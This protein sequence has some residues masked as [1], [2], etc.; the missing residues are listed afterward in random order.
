[1]TFI[2][3]IPEEEA[4][5]NVQQLYAE[6]R[7]FYGYLPNYI[8]AFSH[9]PE[10]M[11]A[12]GNL[13]GAIKAQMDDRRYELVTLAAARALHSSYC[14]LAHG[15][16]LIEQ[17]YTSEQLTRIAKD[18][19]TADLT[20]ADVAMMAFAEKVIRD[21]TTMTQTDIDALKQHGFS[22]AEIFDIAAAAAARCFI[23]K[24]ADALGAE[25][26]EAFL[27]IRE[28]LHPQERPN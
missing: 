1:M 5:G 28:E 27:E 2:N 13:L 26:D 18:Y 16:V 19:R 24:T 3:T 20:P 7:E 22:D 25:P 4:S 10:V 12:W 6:N 23:S 21:A 11:Y 17:F 8:Q 9:R 15:S 14:M